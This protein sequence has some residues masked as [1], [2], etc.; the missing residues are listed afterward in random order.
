MNLRKKII[1]MLQERTICLSL[2]H[3]KRYTP[4]LNGL[5][6]QTGIS[7][8]DVGAAWC[9]ITGGFLTGGA[10]LINLYLSMAHLKCRLCFVQSCCIAFTP[11]CLQG[12]MSGKCADHHPCRELFFLPHIFPPTDGR[13]SFYNI[14]QFISR[15][16]DPFH[17]SPVFRQRYSF[18]H[19]GK[20]DMPTHSSS[21]VMERAFVEKMFCS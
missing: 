19:S 17:F 14:S 10:E 7:V 16:P 6:Q 8:S 18:L 2:L 15:E 9:F 11:K 4:N 12:R 3:M 20:N 21:Y 5:K 1:S 13:D